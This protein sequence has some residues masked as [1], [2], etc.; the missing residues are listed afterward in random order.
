[1]AKNLIWCLILTS[2]GPNL[3]HKFFL[4]VLALPDVKHYCKLLLYGISRETDGPTLRKQQKTQFQAQFW[5]IQLCQSQKM[6]IYHHAQYQK[7][8]NDPILRKLSVYTEG[9]MDSRD[10]QMNESDFI[11]FCLTILEHSKEYFTSEK[12][13][14]Y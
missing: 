5:K 13:V 14:K 10:G 11:G 3:V 4:L 9:W 2:F 8:T 12:K 1:M 6:V 7:K